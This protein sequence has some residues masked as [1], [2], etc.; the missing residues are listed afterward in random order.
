MHLVPGAEPMLQTSR[1][2]LT[3]DVV[4]HV[5]SGRLAVEIRGTQIVLEAGDTLQ[6]TLGDAIRIQA[7]SETAAEFHMVTSEPLEAQ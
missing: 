3:R 4:Y 7:Q 5:Q 6:A 1:H 2:E